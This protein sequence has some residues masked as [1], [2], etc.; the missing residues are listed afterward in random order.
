MSRR[1]RPPHP[2][3]LTPR[4]W[5]V[6]ALLRDGVSN[7]EIAQ[8]LGITLAGAKYHVSEILGKLAVSSREEAAR[9]Q[10]TERP[11]WLAA[12]APVAFLWRKVSVP[13]VSPATT[14][15]LA[16][17]VASGIGLLAWGLLA[18]G[19][20]RTA[21]DDG[22]P[23]ATAPQLAA[24]ERPT[25]T[26]PELP[27]EIIGPVDRDAAFSIDNLGVLAHF[28]LDLPTGQ[29]YVIRSAGP[30]IDFGR[31]RS[32]HWLDDETLLLE[33]RRPPPDSTAILTP[34]SP[35]SP[36]EHI[37]YRARLDGTAILTSPSQIVPPDWQA[38][39]SSPDG[40]WTATLVEGPIDGPIEDT[41]GTIVVGRSNE[42]FTYRL[43][44]TGSSIWGPMPPAWSLTGHLLAFIGNVCREFDLFIFEPELGELRN[45]TAT[46]ENPV[47][48]FA[49]RPDS[50]SLAVS[51][52]RTAE[53]PSSLRLVDLATGAMETLVNS[54]EFAM[55]W[56]LGW[57]PSGERLLFN[58]FQGGWCEGVG[59]DVPF[60]PPTTLEILRD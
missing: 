44:T 38:G 19:L 52:L 32:V 18:W 48:S 13:W 3:I 57:N 39:V 12:A 25:N 23:T 33:M 51:I 2:D 55:P 37:Y 50:S 17:V 34:P 8:R 45:L 10:P 59:F 41:F 42:E 24:T 47:L 49:W 54:P 35:L 9:W 16:V 53:E 1:G 28:I 6:L 27:F 30:D 46:L 43:T 29:F 56:P 21:G 22:G 11:W 15:V 40:P 26:L 31:P 14:A 5:E 58:F 60:P 20:L 7:E 4:E 36:P